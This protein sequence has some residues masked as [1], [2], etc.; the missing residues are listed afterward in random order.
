MESVLLIS[1]HQQVSQELGFARG[2]GQ[3]GLLQGRIW[4]KHAL[5]VK[6]SG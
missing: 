5:I 2:A 1:G 3:T 6:A 4:H